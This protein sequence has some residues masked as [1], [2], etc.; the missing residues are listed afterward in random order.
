VSARWVFDSDAAR[1]SAATT[2]AIAR[3]LDAPAPDT[4]VLGDAALLDPAA[5]QAYARTARVLVERTSLAADLHRH[6]GHLQAAATLAQRHEGVI[7]HALSVLGQVLHTALGPLP[8]LWAGDV[9]VWRWLSGGRARPAVTVTPEPAGAQ[10]SLGARTLADWLGRADTLEPATFA[11]SRVGASVVL[12]LPGIHSVLPTADPRDLSGAAREEL[13]GASAYHE[14]VVE[15]LQRTA[16]PGG[17]RIVVIGHSQGGIVGADLTRDPRVRRIGPVT[18]LLAAGA[19]I[20][21]IPVGAGTR[22]AELVDPDDIVPALDGRATRMRPGRQV[23]VGARA[24]PVRSHAL[25]TYATL[26]SAPGAVD[27]LEDFTRGAPW[28]SGGAAATTIWRAADGRVHTLAP[29]AT[30]RRSA[31]IAPGRVAASQR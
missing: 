18:H 29:G 13:T 14:A 22:V 4:A 12:V 8:Q 24:D 19:P 23:V 31:E 6:S 5:A 20:S 15:A 3:H 30:L 17:V 11:I 2:A 16:L 1:Q 28:L 21:G 26:A 25:Q 9:A 7:A 27:Q 10:W